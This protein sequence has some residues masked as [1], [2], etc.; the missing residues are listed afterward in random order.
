MPKILLVIPWSPL[1]PAGVSVVIRNLFEQYQAMG[2]AAQICQD[3]WDYRHPEAGE[4]N[5]VLLRFGVLG[6]TTPL[7]LL[8]S[9]LSAP[10]HL[11]R[12]A[13]WLSRSEVACVNFHYAGLGALSIACLKSLGLFRGRLVLS[14]HGTDVNSPADPIARKLLAF[15]VRQA[16]TLTFCSRAL[17]EKA[18]KVFGFRHPDGRAIYNGVNTAVFRAGLDPYPGLPARYIVQVG[19]FIPRKRQVFLTQVF[20]SLAADYPDLHLVL[21]GMEGPELAKVRSLAAGQG[22]DGRLHTLMN[23]SPE[24][25]ARI[26]SNATVCV[27]PS[28]SEPF[29]IAT[30]E[31]GACAVPVVA[32]RVEGHLETLADGESGLLFDVDDHAACASAIREVLDD[33]PAATQLARCLQARVREQFTWEH[34]A[35]E[36][37]RACASTAVT[38]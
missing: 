35:A 37:A 13:R 34:C 11:A 12:L 7:A 8:K 3:D 4:G 28:D 1:H 38:S 15:T 2:Q 30:I 24:E 18:V 10:G 26:V 31:A 21:I 20:L 14:F 16:D 32:S 29:G 6:G 25:V 5:V 27:Q 36:Y 22:C 23:L 19:S 17:L 9:L 33:R